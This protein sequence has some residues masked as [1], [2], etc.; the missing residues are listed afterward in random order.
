[1]INLENGIH[2]PQVVDG[3]TMKI[4]RK[5]KIVE[6]YRDGKAEYTIYIRARNHHNDLVWYLL[7]THFG[8]TRTVHFDL[9][10][11]KDIVDYAKGRGDRRIH[12]NPERLMAWVR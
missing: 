1:M 11:A 7:R 6:K 2:E 10:T 12:F 4:G 8:D 9:E 5:F 3:I